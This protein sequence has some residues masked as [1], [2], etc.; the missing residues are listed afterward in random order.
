MTNIVIN[1]CERTSAFDAVEVVA[2]F[3]LENRKKREYLHSR[4]IHAWSGRILNV[5]ERYTEQDK[6]G[7]DC[8][9]QVVRTN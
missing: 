9:F 6:L 5:S 1:T 8:S 2:K 3:I 7:C 4:E